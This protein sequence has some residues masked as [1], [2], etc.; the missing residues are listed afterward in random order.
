VRRD[1]GCRAHGRSF[2]LDLRM[3][4][5][6]VPFLIHPHQSSQ[7]QPPNLRVFGMT[8]RLTTRLN[9]LGEGNVQSIHTVAS[10]RNAGITPRAS[11]D[12]GVLC[13]QQTV[14]LSSLP[15]RRASSTADVETEQDRS[16]L[17]DESGSP[18]KLSVPI[19]LQILDEDASQLL[20]NDEE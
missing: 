4:H 13:R 8:K 2:F 1:N 17:S 7:V 15:I 10:F 5:K 11:L 20:A 6:N 9:K 3:G 16:E 14:M 12:A 19:C 18:E